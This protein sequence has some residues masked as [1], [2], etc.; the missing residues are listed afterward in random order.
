[1]KMNAAN[2]WL[3]AIWASSYVFIRRIPIL[4]LNKGEAAVFQIPIMLKALFVM[5]YSND[6]L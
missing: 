4:L 6:S 5:G 3:S 1:M 2:R